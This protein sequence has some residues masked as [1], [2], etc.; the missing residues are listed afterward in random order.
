[1]KFLAASLIAHAALLAGL[2]FLVKEKPEPAVRWPLGEVFLEKGAE[3]AAAGGKRG[4]IGQ[5]PSPRADSDPGAESGAAF[6]EAGGANATEN[7]G[8][9]DGEASATT[10][11]TI[12]Y[13]PLSVRQGESGKVQVG[14]KI[15]ASGRVEAARVNRSSGYA[16]LDDAA[17]RALHAV[18]FSP[19]RRNG[20]AVD[21]EKEITVD[22]RLL[23]QRG[24]R[25]TPRVELDGR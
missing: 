3:R 25:R 22:F 13:P 6:G 5:V 1:M 21:S 14:L 9:P 11:I 23:E 18:E 12:G 4:E 10:E 17:V 24:G 2:W 19:A 15:L 8:A 16:R 7:P 20:A